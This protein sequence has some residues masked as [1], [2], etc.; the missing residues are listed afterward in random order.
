M[1]AGVL[2]FFLW[3]RRQQSAP[4]VAE[5]P[6]P[7]NTPDDGLNPVL[8]G[9]P[10]RTGS[11]LRQPSNGYL[12]GAGAFA[13]HGGHDGSSASAADVLNGGGGHR[14]NSL[15]SGSIL[16]NLTAHHANPHDRFGSDAVAM[17]DMR[18][19][20]PAG[21]GQGSRNDKIPELPY[22]GRR[23]A[24]YHGAPLMEHDGYSELPG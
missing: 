3:R 17:H 20:P 19:T 24:P 8:N 7:R 15:H 14:S 13:L 2:A 11:I 6:P 12:N 5:S 21:W 10:F 1:I 4:A 22:D 18:R 16:S 9:P 23:L